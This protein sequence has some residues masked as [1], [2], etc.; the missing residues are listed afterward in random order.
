[1][2]EKRKPEFVF[3]LRKR[4]KK[5]RKVELFSCYQWEDRY[6]K[7]MPRNQV[8]RYRIR[9]N[10]KWHGNGL[11]FFSLSEFKHLMFKSLYKL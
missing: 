4:G 1:M 3:L 5:N 9:V 6:P 8:E 10:G 2:S 11:E 7:K